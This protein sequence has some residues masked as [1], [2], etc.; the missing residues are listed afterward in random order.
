M[1]EPRRPA[2]TAAAVQTSTESWLT[3]NVFCARATSMS[4]IGPKYGLVPALLTRMS[5]PPKRATR[6]GHAGLRRP[7]ASRR[8]RRSRPPAPPGRPRR[9]GPPPPRPGPPPCGSVIMTLAPASTKRAAMR[10]ADA[11]APPVIS[12]VFPFSSSSI[13]RA[14]HGAAGVPRSRRRSPS[15]APVNHL[16]DETS[17][18]LRQHA[19]N[20]VEWFPWGDEAL[21]RAQERGQAASSSPS[22]TPRAT[23]ATSWPTR[24]SRTR[25]RRRTWPSGSSRSRSTAR[26]VP[27]STPSTWRPPRP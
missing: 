22:A 14:L 21:R 27:I 3:S 6:L 13:A 18:Y 17:P 15:I 20:P 2:L 1:T 8:G 25:P 12:A 7:R 23:G 11:P 26:S 4:I 19:D 5:R 24:A 10:Q 16:A 9:P